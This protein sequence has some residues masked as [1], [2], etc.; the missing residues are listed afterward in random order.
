MLKK[1]ILAISL[2]IFLFYLHVNT[3]KAENTYNL[4]SL[5]DIH[6]FF[7]TE[8]LH[9]SEWQILMRDKVNIDI[10]NV[11]DILDTQFPNASVTH[12]IEDEQTIKILINNHNKMTGFNEQLSIVRQKN[13]SE[14][15]FKY[16]LKG[17]KWNEEVEKEVKN[18]LSQ[19][20]L[21]LFDK[22]PTIFTCMR[23]Q[24]NDNIKSNYLVDSFQDFMKMDKVKTINEENFDT[25]SGYI[26]NW[27]VEEIPIS[28]KEKMNVQIAVRNGLSHGANVI[29]G[30][31]I[32]VTE[33]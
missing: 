10:K 12:Q 11:D 30:T 6:T 23:A 8:Q 2:L 17:D 24:S 22:N 18:T 4:Q 20:V 27:T 32:L 31:P 7:Q 19:Q 33:Y 15:E 26:H 5:N 14:A 28:Q 29:I 3:P 9:V 16:I 21:R 13:S 25:V 1:A